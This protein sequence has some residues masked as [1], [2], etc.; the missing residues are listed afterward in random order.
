M[1]VDS[2]LASGDLATLLTGQ[3]AKLPAGLAATK[4]AWLKALRA[5]AVERVGALKLP[6]SHDEAW[7]FT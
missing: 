3:A 7:R 5:Q 6:T 4:P 1:S 2:T